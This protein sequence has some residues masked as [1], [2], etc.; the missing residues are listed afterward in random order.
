LK[1]KNV[2]DENIRYLEIEGGRHEPHTWGEA[3]PDFLR[4]A[5]V[6]ELGQ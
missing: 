2:R 5:F 4:W 6:K 3:M 1:T